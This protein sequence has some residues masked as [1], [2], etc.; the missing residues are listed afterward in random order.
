MSSLIDSCPI[1]P[2]AKPNSH[3]PTAPKM[4]NRSW[5]SWKENC[6]SWKKRWR[7]LIYP[8]Q[9]KKNRAISW[10]CWAKKAQPRRMWVPRRRRPL[11]KGRRI[12]IKIM[13]ESKKK[14]SIFPR[15]WKCPIK[16]RST[17]KL[18][19][20]RRTVVMMGRFT[21]KSS[22][23]SKRKRALTTIFSKTPKIVNREG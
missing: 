2:S 20:Q 11:N 9:T 4:F 3:K 21:L 16:N 22:P 12:R 7:T 13:T 6:S 19:L 14:A 18:I 8:H 10:V 17:N 1:T 23:K 5:A 15:T